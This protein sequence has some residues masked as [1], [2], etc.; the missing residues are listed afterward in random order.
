MTR[1]SSSTFTP[2]SMAEHHHF[3]TSELPKSNMSLWQT[4]RRGPIRSNWIL[5][6]YITS[7]H[8]DAISCIDLLY[9]GAV[10]YIVVGSY[11]G[12]VSIWNVVSPTIVHKKQKFTLQSAPIRT[13]QVVRGAIIICNAGHVY[14]LMLDNQP[15]LWY[16]LGRPL[17]SAELATPSPYLVVVSKSNCIILVDVSEVLIQSSDDK[18]EQSK[19]LTKKQIKEI[20]I[21][22][23]IEAT[24]LKT[25]AVDLDGANEHTQQAAESADLH[26]IASVN[27]IANTLEDSEVENEDVCARTAYIACACLVTPAC[28]VLVCSHGFFYLYNFLLEEVLFKS[29]LSRNAVATYISTKYMSSATRAEKV[30]ISAADGSLTVWRLSIEKK[31]LQPIAMRSN[32]GSAVSCITLSNPQFVVLGLSNG[33]VKLYEEDNISHSVGVCR[34]VP[35][36]QTYQTAGISCVLWLDPDTLIT[37]SWDRGVFIYTRPHE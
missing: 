23:V 36:D 6:S 34:A 26:R 27:T 37:G 11:D 30:Y 7:V 12:V 24:Q 18:G 15:R 5:S 22:E 13:L 29:Q 1:F 8:G 35:D 17:I 21:S 9:V 20:L 10:R 3:T 32:Y 31:E 4:I 2:A 14:H 28:L 25:C 16:E 33:K 19:E